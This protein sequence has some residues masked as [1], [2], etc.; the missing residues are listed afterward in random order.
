[1]VAKLPGVG[2]TL[3][4][5]PFVAVNFAAGAR[6]AQPPWFQVLLTCRSSTAGGG[7]HL[8]IFPAGPV[9]DPAGPFFGFFTALVK[10]L[11]RGRLRFRSADPR[12]APEID[13]GYFSHPAD[14]HR[15]IEAVRVVHR[16]AR[17]PPLAGMVGD[18]LTP[19]LA[20]GSSDAALAAGI[21]ARVET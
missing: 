20:I 13:P 14:L 16:L 11:S 1:M 8:Q 6:P 21:R 12:A 3:A 5:L 2:S 7:H 17:T 10:P 4:E 15:L 18:E 9:A 19:D